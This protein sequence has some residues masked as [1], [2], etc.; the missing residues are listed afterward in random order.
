VTLFSDG[1][2]E[3]PTITSEMVTQAEKTLGYKLPQSYVAALHEKNGGDLV[4]GAFPT[5]RPTNWANNHV[6][7]HNLMGVGCENG[8]DSE[9]GSQYLIE[10][11]EYPD[12]GVVFST[13]GHTAFMLDHSAC[14]TQGE[15]SVIYVDTE[16]DLEVFPLAHTFTAFLSGLVED[17]REDGEDEDDD[18][19]TA[20]L[21]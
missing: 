15:P 16:P 11:W 13:E 8:M 14:G 5:D 18:D 10:E 4:C 1:L 19:T 20:D 7:C 3:C 6:F 21:T 2:N 12:V 9:L 17:I